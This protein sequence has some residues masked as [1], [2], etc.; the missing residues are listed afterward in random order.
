VADAYVERLWEALARAWPRLERRVAA[1]RVELTHDVDDPLASLGRDT[2]ARARQLA[3]DAL[4]RRDAALVARRLRSWAAAR[5]GD[6]R[7]DP[8]NTFDVLMAAAERHG[9]AGVFNFL[10]TERAGPP[11]GSYT[12]NDPW[13][14]A[15]LRRLHERGHE[16]GFHAG[17]H[18]MTDARRTAEEFARLRSTAER[19][20]VVQKRWGGRQHYLRWRNPVTWANWERA[21][22]DYDSTVGFPDAIGFRAGTCHDYRAFDLLERRPLQLREHPLHVM[23]ITLTQYLRLSPE[24]ALAAVAEVAREC[25][26]HNGTLRLLW[27]NSSLP[28]ARQQRWYQALVDTVS[29]RP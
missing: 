28:S 16:V 10:A 22:L 21:G 26:R 6:H 14:L 11:E 13:V 3:A 29:G 2:R 17:F 27:H 19:H 4:V 7:G 18:T 12:L 1:Y 24:A 5:R 9:I 23:D 8:Y 25:R 20:G 15:L